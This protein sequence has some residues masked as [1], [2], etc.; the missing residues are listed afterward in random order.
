M[1]LTELIKGFSY[2]LVGNCEIEGIELDAVTT[3]SHDA[4]PAH[5]YICTRTA[6]RDGHYAAEVAYQ[7]GCR[8][9]LAERTLILPPDATVLVVE[10]TEALTGELAAR[11]MGHPARRMTL[12]GV[13]GSVGK[14]SVACMLFSMLRAAGRRAAVLLPTGVLE[15]KGFA[16]F[17]NIMPDGAEIAEILRNFEANGVEYVILA[18][19]SYMLEHKAAFSLPFAA[20]LLTNL[21]PELPG[22]GECPNPRAHCRAVASLL[23]CDAP[24]KLLPTELD[25]ACEGGRLLRFGEG[26]DF[27]AR[28][29]C[30]YDEGGG[31][32]FLLTY[33][34]GSANAYTPVPG[35]AAINN[36]LA[37]SALAVTVGLGEREILEGLR[38]PVPGMLECIADFSGR[39]IYRDTAYSPEALTRAL[40]TL[41]ECCRGKLTV[42]LGSVGGRAKARRL[43]LAAAAERHADFVYL[44][45]DNPDTEDPMQICTRMAQGFEDASRYVIIPDRQAAIERAVLEMR[46][47]DVLLLAGKGRECFQLVNGQR[48]PFDERKIVLG[49]AKHF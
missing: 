12:L 42:L 45:A 15:E 30:R 24:F 33:P 41:G 49:L 43:P 26:G 48:L 28:D 10:D 27:S 44:T 4:T 1:R 9:F 29:I 23:A 25:L 17:G 18:L 14:S 16:P 13:S 31:S 19:S 21:S 7:G 5:L 39:R 2:R 8:L 37:A 6:L 32:S 35:R 36:A 11:L 46:P 22:R 40:L 20:V 34:G 3:Q 38:Q 47:G